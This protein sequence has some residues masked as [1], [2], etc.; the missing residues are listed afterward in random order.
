MQTSVTYLL[1]AGASA[2]ALPTVEKLPERLNA[3]AALI[4]SDWK[5][6][7]K[8]IFQ[9]NGDFS[10]SV[11]ESLAGD[12]RWLAETSSEHASVDTFAKKLYLIKDLPGLKRLKVALTIFF[13][14]EEAHKP[15]DIRYDSFLASLLQNDLTLPNNLRILSWNYDSQLERA[16]SKFNQSKEIEPSRR[17]L[18][19]ISRN[20]NIALERDKFAIIKLNGHCSVTIKN[21]EFIFNREF[22][23]IN[24]KSELASVYAS[25][26]NISD[27]SVMID[28]SISFAWES[29]PAVNDPFIH[30]IWESTS[31]T[32]T[33][34]IIGYSFP[35]FN[36]EVDRAIFGNMPR[37]NKVYFQSKESIALIQKF[38][39]T[40][41]D[42]RIREDL[43][44]PIEVDN[45]QFFLPPE[46]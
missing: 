8:E 26:S 30:N 43:L 3:I 9:V 12:L 14:L 22:L 35:F 31:H 40:I 39:S 33:L 27:P 19:H 37:L 41:I 45:K 6:S 5:M 23:R 28:S 10:Y 46:L 2:Q 4:E 17:N 29:I 21:K 36:R 18:N 32:E 44:I 24:N 11:I 34:V 42:T 1:G 16:Y 15:P 13:I 7:D 20:S 25:Y 38:T